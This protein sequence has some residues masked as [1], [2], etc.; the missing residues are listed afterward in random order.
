M[1][2]QCGY[3]K[4]EEMEI[5]KKRE[6]YDL[7]DHCMVRLSPKMKKRINKRRKRADNG[8]IQT[9]TWK[10]EQLCKRSEV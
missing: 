9:I 8:E 3:E 10:N 7:S 1:V 6:I 5:D 2:N 4:F